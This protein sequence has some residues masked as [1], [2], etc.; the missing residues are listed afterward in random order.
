MA[1]VSDTIPNLVNGVSQQPAA[2][3][4]ASQC[5][6]SENAYHSIVEGEKKRA[7]THHIAKLVDSGLIGDVYVHTINRDAEERYKV[8]LVDGALLVFDLAGEEKGV[9]VTNAAAP[10]LTTPTPSQSFRAI[11]VQDHTFIINR[12]VEVAMLNTTVE[13]PGSQGL[14]Y[15]QQGSYGTDYKIYV[16]DVE[17]AT[18]TTSNTDVT[19]LKTD[20]IAEDLKTDLVSNLGAGWTIS[21]EGS[22]ILIKKDNASSFKLRATDSN[23]DRNTVVVKEKIQRFASLPSTAPNDF[24]VE[25]TGDPDGDEDNYFVKFETQDEGTTFGRGVWKE[26]AQ[27]GITFELDAATMPHILVREEDG[28]FTFDVADW[29]T[30]AVGDEESNPEPSFVGRSLNDIFFWRNRLGLLADENVILSR[31]GAFFDFFRQSVITILDDDP[32]DTASTSTKVSILTAA[33]PAKKKL[34]LFADQTQFVLETGDTILTPKSAEIDTTTAFEVDPGARPIMAGKNIYF[35]VPRGEFSGIREYFIDRDT[36]NEDA[37]D[38]TAHVPAYVPKGIFKIAAATNEDINLFL[39][40]EER[41][42]VWAYKFYWST[43][44][45]GSPEKLQSAWGIWTFGDGVRVLDVDFI[46]MDVYLVLEREDGIY[47]EVLSVD[48]D[49]KDEDLDYEVLLDRRITDEDCGSITFDGSH[50]TWVL[51]YKESETMRIVTRPGGAEKAGVVVAH[52]VDNDGDTTELTALGDFSEQPVYIGKTYI[53]HYRPGQIMLRQR[54]SSGA[55]TVVTS[56][57]LQLQKMTL[58]L[59][60]TG[61][62]KAIVTPRFGNAFEY[63]FTGRILGSGTN[64]IGQTSLESGLWSFPIMSKNDRVTIDLVSDSHLPVR[65]QSAEWTGLFIAHS[66]RIR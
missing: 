49:R 39:S 7:P 23:G 38:I 1:L 58:T 16:D 40:S 35:V 26:T 19:T 47:L 46:N 37:A 5:E 64:I 13:S 41:D 3:R 59:D 50:T 12:D 62:V 27:P 36:N 18:Y 20:A 56:G 25:V 48:A 57:R 34:F 32:I 30:R 63:I 6:V 45:S 9:A 52:T 55:E 4:L 31:A 60:R 53:W 14:V 44:A 43:N 29:G 17:Q 15:V 10:Y 42:T 51:P 54:D 8:L 24:V 33:I 11:T 22:T 61:Y 28:S 65:I 2:L 21:R 66:Q